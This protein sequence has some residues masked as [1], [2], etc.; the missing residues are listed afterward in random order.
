MPFFDMPLEQ[1]REYRPERNEPADFDVFWQATL[2]AA[3]QY[4]LNAQY[5]A[6][7]LWAGYR[8]RRLMLP[9]RATVGNP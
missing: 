8:L 3:R 5:R 7:G 4:P 1:L 6:G 2:E 9:L